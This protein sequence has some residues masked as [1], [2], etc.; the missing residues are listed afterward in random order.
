MP[1]DSSLQILRQSCLLGAL[2]EQEA[3]ELLAYTRVR[4]LE[5]EASLFHERMPASHF[6]LV[7]EGQIKVY[8][9]SAEGKEAVLN[10]FGP[11]E[12][13]AEQ[14]IYSGLA[15]YPASAMAL[16][17][18]RV[19]A[20]QG[21]AFRAWASQRPDVL[22]RIMGR[23]SRRLHDFSRQVSELSL[24]SVDCRLARY[25]LSLPSDAAGL[26]QLPIPKKT[27]AAMLGTIP[28]TLSRSFRRLVE[29]DAIRSQGN[30]IALADQGKLHELAE[31]RV[32]CLGRCGA[33]RRS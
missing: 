29:L 13:L 9:L 1:Q 30:A 7:L 28:E 16:Q 11:G 2:S 5:A 31:T 26:I 19:L 14:P 10:V 6:F 22:L 32:S 27:L 23:M 3:K 33:A 15:L 24:L 20:I 25:L 8:R 17:P 12:A 18:S 4:E 21:E